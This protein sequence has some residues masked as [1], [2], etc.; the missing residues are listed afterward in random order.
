MK[1]YQLLLMSLVCYQLQAAEAPKKASTK[2]LSGAPTRQTMEEPISKS[3]APVAKKAHQKEIEEAR[4]KAATSAEIKKREEKSKG[5][6]ARISD[7][8]NL[9]NLKNT[10]YYSIAQ[11]PYLT[12]EKIADIKRYIES[13]IDP[14]IV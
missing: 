4:K 3:E 13:G 7:W 6:F 11:Y 10:I 14:N 2:P 1:I 8:Y 9:D 5:I 12:K